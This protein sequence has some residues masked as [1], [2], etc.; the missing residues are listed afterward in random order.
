VGPRV[1]AIRKEGLGLLRYARPA[2]AL[3]IH[4]SM[5]ISSD[6]LS[7]RTARTLPHCSGAVPERGGRRRTFERAPHLHLS[8][9]GS[10]PVSRSLASYIRDDV[11][12]LSHVMSLLVRP[13]RPRNVLRLFCPAIP[14]RPFSCGLLF[15]N[16]QQ[17]CFEHL[18]ALPPNTP[19]PVPSV[20]QE[21]EKRYARSDGV[22]VWS[23]IWTEE[24]TNGKR[25]EVILVRGGE[26]EGGWVA[27]WQLEA[28]VCKYLFGSTWRGERPP[29]ELRQNLRFCHNVQLSCGLPSPTRSSPSRP[30]SLFARS[31][32]S[33]SSPA[34]S[35]FGIVRQV[36]ASP[37]GRGS[38]R[39]R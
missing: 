9:P 20:G 14:F 3:G 5:L 32:T 16:E 17:P 29:A 10:R 1:G 2:R 21:D 7:R 11:V 34:M 27:V 37:P 23:T 19:V 36:D 18:S 35:S 22:S 28:P 12:I 6:L 33:V 24:M 13:G 8:P 26:K 31:P 38:K 25:N 4:P 15:P 39:R 30:P